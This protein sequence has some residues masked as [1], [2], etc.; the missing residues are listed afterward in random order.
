M[1]VYYSFQDDPL[2]V[3]YRVITFRGS[4]CVYSSADLWRG[5]DVE[6]GLFYD[7]ATPVNTAVS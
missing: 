6:M 4:D 7:C 5:E 3:L 1:S 2:F